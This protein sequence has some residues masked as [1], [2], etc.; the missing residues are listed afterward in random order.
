MAYTQKI[1]FYKTRSFSQKLNAT[2][3]FIRQNAKPLGKS[4]LFILGPLAILNG[5][6]F[7]QYMDFMFGNMSPQDPLNAQ[8]P[9]A[10]FTNPSYIGF[11]ILSTFSTLVNFVIVL[12]YMKLYQS[13]YPDEISVTEV[14]NA[15]LR[16][17]LPILLLSI[18]VIIIDFMG[19]MLFLIPGMYLMIVL[20]MAFPALLFEGKGIFESIG[21]GFKLISGK[22]WSTF[23]L[24]LV[25]SILMYAIS[26]VFIAPFYVFYFMTIFSL[27][28]V[29]GMGTNTSA[30]WFQG[31]MTLSVML[32]FIGSFMAYSIPIVALSFQYFNLVERKESTGLM[33]EINQLNTTKADID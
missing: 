2:I 14:L 32:M 15:S 18:V 33:S 16:D 23:G 7:S 22:W 6:L 1:V 13:K 31:G 9:F 5:L 10:A 20:S 30:W 19:L 24:L 21:R 26:L 17:I 3:E 27:Q 11:L 8:N 4:I 25:A 28:D 12:N 29:S